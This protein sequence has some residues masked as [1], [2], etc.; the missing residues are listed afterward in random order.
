MLEHAREIIVLTRDKTFEDLTTDRMLELS[1][2]RLLEILGEAARRVSSEFREAHPEV[3]WGDVSG[4]RDRLIHV[5]DDI[6]LGTVWHTATEDVPELVAQ[7]E[8]ILR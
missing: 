3:P 8:R 1:V 6:N 2:T 5:Y 4:M 7:L